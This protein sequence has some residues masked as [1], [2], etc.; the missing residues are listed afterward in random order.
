M[1]CM[2][3]VCTLVCLFST[4]AHG[5]RC[6]DGG[7]MNNGC[8]VKKFE[9]IHEY[10]FIQDGSNSF[11]FYIKTCA[12]ADMSISLFNRKS[13][14][15]ITNIFQNLFTINI[16]SAGANI[17]HKVNVKKVATINNNFLYNI[18]ELE[19]DDHPS[20]KYEQA[21]TAGNEIHVESSVVFWWSVKCDPR[22]YYSH[23][24]LPSPTPISTNT[25]HIPVHR[26]ECEN[27]YEEKYRGCPVYKIESEN[28]C[29]IYLETNGG[30]G[31]FLFYIKPMLRREI[32][33]ISL[34]RRYNSSSSIM[35]T[36]ELFTS[37]LN[38]SDINTWYKMNIKRSNKIYTLEA[39]NN[40]TVIQSKEMEAGNEIRVVTISS[41]WSVP[42]ATLKPAT[43]GLALWQL[44][45]I[46][47][48]A[49]MLAL[50][51]ITFIVILVRRH[52]KRKSDQDLTESTDHEARLSRHVSENSLYASHDNHSIDEN[53][54]PQVTT[55]S[56][57]TSA[58][59]R[60][61]SVHDSENSLYM[62]F[63]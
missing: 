63:N 44:V 10:V 12:E 61:G 21:I 8:P 49:V 19:I 62:G 30:D 48:V 37:R 60:R 51:V 39:N 41:S 3:Y 26:N 1:Y 2:L 20:S 36:D 4:V 31:N 52:K 18:Y 25:D 56:A 27:K 34:H 58:N 45:I 15:S 38:Y 47:A 40:P 9:P 14:S 42:C 6:E 23:T 28:E 59:H 55:A 53:Q 50:V 32:L 13:K 54:V 24:Q 17:W 22:Q 57:T 7:E 16:T 5:N 29:Q 35:I 11:V 46:A 43:V 33:S